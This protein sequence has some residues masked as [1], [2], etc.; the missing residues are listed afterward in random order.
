MRRSQ[1]VQTQLRHLA[2]AKG[3]V[4]SQ[5]QLAGLNEQSSLTS[6]QYQTFNGTAA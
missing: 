1:E 2:S 3:S 5:E 4:P 6:R